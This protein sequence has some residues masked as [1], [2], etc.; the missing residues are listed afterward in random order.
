MTEASVLAVVVAYGHSDA[1][2]DCVRSLRKQRE[3]SQVVVVDNSG[4]PDIA[5]ECRAHGAL[6]V[7]PGANLGYSRGAHA[8]VVAGESGGTHVLIVNPDLVLFDLKPLLVALEERT[9]VIVTGCLQRGDGEVEVNSRAIAT[10]WTEFARACFGTRVIARRRPVVDGRREGIGQAAGSLLLVRR[11]DW[12]A[13]G[14]FDQRFEL[15]FE[16]VDL[17][18]RAHERG[19]VMRV[20]TVVGTHIG[21]LSYRSNQGP[22][23]IVA[24]ISRTR[25]LRKWYGRK[26][27]LAAAAVSLLEYVVRSLTGQAEGQCVRSKA[28][29]CQARELRRPNSV[30]VLTGPR[31]GG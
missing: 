18:R 10:P 13:L 8:G 16:D 28:L 19:Q 24:S 31:V 25:Y 5:S 30:Q 27:T 11:G 1:V 22:G 21:G 15:Y 4:D 17:C 3:I 23:Y 2:A 14:G 6:Y 20:N 9:T 29:R 26:G 12:I 7:D